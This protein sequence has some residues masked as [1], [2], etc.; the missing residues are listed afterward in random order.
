MS[1]KNNILIKD[2]VDYG[3]SEKE[4]QVY[5]ALLELEIA[6]VNEVAK[7]SGVNRSSTYVVIESLKEKGL[8]AVSDDTSVQQFVASSPEV[9]LR[10]AHESAQ[11]QTELKEKIEN[12]VPELKALHKDT[13]MRPRVRVFEGKEGVKNVYYDL[14]SSKAT[15]LRTYANPKHIFKLLPDFLDHNNER[16]SKG[17]KMYAINPLTI[18]TRMMLKHFPKEA[19]DEVVTIP[20]EKFRFSS[21]M[22]IYGDKVSFV[23]TKEKFGVIIESK[24]FANMIRSSFD[25]SWAEA[26]RL[27]KEKGLPNR[28]DS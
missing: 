21:D 10:T 1:S 22:G 8:V 6:P 27:N 16:I 28:L 11:K 4:A 3:L 9:L 18:G 24:E 14:F 15:E 23:S 5:I 17:I 25:L 20:K 2:L 13:K 12:I 26:K 19:K 7:K